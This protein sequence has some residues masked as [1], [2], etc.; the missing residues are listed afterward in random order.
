MNPL[1]LIRDAVIRY[2]RTRGFG[3]HS[4]FAYG[5]ITQV[6]GCR[7]PFY[8]WDDLEAEVRDAG[9]I[10]W[11]DTRALFRTLNQMSPSVVYVAPGDAAGVKRVIEKWSGSCKITADS[12]EAS[13]LILGDE[14]PE[15]VDSVIEGGKTVFFTTVKNPMW[16]RLNAAMKRG[17]TFTNSVTGIVICNEKLPRHY[18]EISY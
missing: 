6:L 8:C 7:Y 5:F 12:G 11:R 14:A 10:R 9:K 13:F 1:R 3:V 18:F 2:R 4:P 17:Q 15:D 16:K